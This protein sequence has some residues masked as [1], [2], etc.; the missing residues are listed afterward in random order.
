MDL[1]HL[2]DCRD[3]TRSRLNLAPAREVVVRGSLV[4]DR[5]HRHDDVSDR[6]LRNEPTGAADGHEDA[7]PGLD[8][9]LQEH[10]GQW[11]AHSRG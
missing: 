4:S 11:S 10:P 6:Q 2:L 1:E 7:A 9:L 3:G 8:D 5:G